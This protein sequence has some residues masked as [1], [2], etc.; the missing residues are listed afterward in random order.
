MTLVRHLQECNRFDPGRFVPLTYQDTRVGLI[1]RDHLAVLDERPDLFAVTGDGVSIAA[2]GSAATLT[3]SLV[4]FSETLAQRGL[5]AA[6]RQEPF[7]VSFAWGGPTLFAVDRGAV[8][9]FG[10]RSYGVHLNGLRN[11]DIDQIWIG[12]RARDKRV[13]PGKLDNMVAGGISA[14]Y[15]AGQT[16]IKEAAEE[17]SMPAELAR[18]AHPSSVIVYRMEVESGVRDDVL[19]VY[20][21]ALPAEFEPRNA[22]GEFESFELMTLDG[23][24]DLI[25]RTDAFKFNVNL[26]LIDLAIRR[27]AI[28]PDHPEYL[29]L[30]LGLRGNQGSKG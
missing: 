17:A 13:A 4:E 26:V 29:A 6:L 25:A 9:F 5:I 15:D 10:T 2:D 22:D 11:G 16:L 23:C 19:L 8:P 12:K 30:A 14:G 21:I 27:G 20:D 3:A 18:L 24:L 7:A 1:R 28:G